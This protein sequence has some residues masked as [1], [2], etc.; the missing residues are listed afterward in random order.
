MKKMKKM[1]KMNAE[2]KYL[3]DGEEKPDDDPEKEM[4][5][6]RYDAGLQ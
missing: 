5:N 3:L 2:V 4:K 6:C 1:K